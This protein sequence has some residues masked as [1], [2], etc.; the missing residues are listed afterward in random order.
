MRSVGGAA[1]RRRSR[2]EGLREA[3]TIVAASVAACAAGAAALSLVRSADYESTAVVSGASRDTPLR[4]AA[5]ARRALAAAG[6]RGERPAALL[7]HLEAERQPGGRA[8]FT[9]SAVEPVAARRLAG[10]YARAWAASAQARAGPTRPARPERDTWRA[11]VTGAAAG[12]LA[13]LL[14]AV[15]REGLDVRRASSRS[16]RARLGFEQLG[17]VP[18]P[19][20]DIEEAY[21]LPAREAPDGDVARAY[22]R[23]AATVAAA[24]RAASARVILVCGIVAE[25]RG[26]LVAAGLGAALAGTGRSVA[27]VELDPARPALRRQFALPRGPGFAE[28]ARGEA[29]VDEALARVRGLAGVSVLTAGAGPAPAGEHVPAALRDR[30]DLVV[31][32]GPPLLGKGARP[33]AGADALLLTVSLRRSRQSRRPRVERVLEEHGVPVLGFVLMASGGPA[34]PGGA[35]RLSE[36][37]A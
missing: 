32:A 36:A 24:A 35:V 13:G 2:R 23:L 8:A 34:S 27:V 22:E 9:V 25:D 6:A 21:R 3:L 12:L 18:E 29:T 4:S 11:A 31:V 16:V 7:G 20:E 33:P 26:E 14:L 17:R 37:R 30:F 10:S 19:P 28:V 15:A 5:V 1:R